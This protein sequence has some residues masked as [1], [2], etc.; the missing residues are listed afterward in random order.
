MKQ[1]TAII[2]VV[3]NA[4]LILLKVIA[5]TLTGSVA[6]LTEAVHSS[7]DLIASV[8]AFASIRVAEE[9]ADPTHAYG[10]D[11]VENLAAAIEAVLI[12]LGSA[13]IAFAAVR[14]LITGGHDHVF[15]V[16][17]G[18]LGASATVNLVVSQVIARN[19][20][21]TNS[22]ALEGDAA[23]LRTDAVSTVGVLIAFI[24][25]D[26]TGAQWIDPVAALI[27]AGAIV[28]T[29]V[30]LALRAGQV[31]VDQSLPDAEVSA[32]EAVVAG[33]G[34]HGVVGF[35]ALRTR[36]AG[37]RRHVDLHVQFKPGTSLE[38][39]HRVSHELQDQIAAVLNGADVLMHLE[40]ADRVRPGQR[41]AHTI[42]SSPGAE[43]SRTHGEGARGAAD[44]P[45]GAGPS[46][47]R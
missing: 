43:S 29:G 3:S 30:R 41:F 1:R 22:P 2:S 12:L 27:V 42:T 35:H 6:I 19:A 44:D 40:P 15:G 11:K 14:R 28:F 4:T 46:A 33:F 37:S 16:G 7:V 25:V 26:I 20:R 31:L 45:G 38:D 32:V 24:L 9:P 36:A 5:G 47:S 17:I 8:V 39:A 10:H 18:V 13:L 23:H 34:D 21:R